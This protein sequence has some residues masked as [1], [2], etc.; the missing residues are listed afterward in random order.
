[1]NMRAIIGAVLVTWPLLACDGADGDGGAGASGE[2]GSETPWIFTSDAPEHRPAGDQSVFA[3]IDVVIKVIDLEHLAHSEDPDEPPVHMAMLSLVE[4]NRGAPDKRVPGLQVFANGEEAPEIA[5]ST[6]PEWFSF[7]HQVRDPVRGKRTL[8]EIHYQGASFA[9]GAVPLEVEITSPEP[10][11]TVSSDRLLVRWTAVDEAPETFFAG[12]GSEKWPAGPIADNQT[13][14]TLGAPHIDATTGTPC[15][16]LV[17]A[18]WRVRSELL[19]ETPFRSFRVELS[20]RRIRLFN[21]E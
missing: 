21:V 11:Q 12:C 16:P 7:Q 1:M 17:S 3:D 2:G 20:V 8:M 5:S 14:V 9:I 15:P 13:S 18:D 10:G 4:I 6:T 19:P